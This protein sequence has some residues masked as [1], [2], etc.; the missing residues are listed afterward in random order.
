MGRGNKKEAVA[1]VHRVQIMK[2]AEKLFLEKGYSQTTIEDISKASEYSRRTIYAYYESKDDILHH[3]IEQGLMEL[4]QNI[5]NAIDIK[6]DFITVYKAICMAMSKY[7]SK[8]PVSADKVNGANASD[9][10]F[11]KLSDTEKHI[12]I[13]G[14]EINSTLA[15]FIEN[16]KKQGIVR[17]DVIPMLT[18]Y[19]LWSGITSFLTLAQQKGQFISKEFSISENNFLEYGFNQ[20]INA[21]LEV[22]IEQ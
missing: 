19:I 7:Q 15:A 10:D 14:T 17:Q 11:E 6:G 2:A 12:L 3:I 8:Y 13:L 22:K 1:A 21:I 9:F 5:E 16:G 18:V 20:L 4:K